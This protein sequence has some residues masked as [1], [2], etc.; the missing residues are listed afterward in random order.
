MSEVNNRIFISR[1]GKDGD[2]ATWAA[3][4][5]ESHGY[6]CVIQDRDFR[7]GERFPLNMLEA[8][9]NC[10]TTLAIMSPDYWA[11]PFCRDEW[12][13]AYALDRSGEGRLIPVMLQ[14]SKPPRLNAALSY[15]DL[16]RTEGDRAGVLRAAVDSVVKRDA[17]LPSQLEPDTHP[18]TN[19]TFYT[20]NFTGRPA[21]LKALYDALWGETGAAAITAAVHGLGGWGRPAKC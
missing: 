7:I 1:T 6:E 12:A 15:L 18:F 17:K 8:F 19:S 10:A 13:A 21:E 14:A 11:S 20:A 3:G 16:T 4:V 5:L 9:E 2:A